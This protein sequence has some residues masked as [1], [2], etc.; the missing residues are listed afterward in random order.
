MAYRIVND[1]PGPESPARAA[2]AVTPNDDTDLAGGCRGL[3][4][5]TGGDL[6]LILA[7]DSAAVTFKNAISGT[8]L[9]LCVKRVKATGTTA[10]DIVALY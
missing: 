6:A 3:Y 9:P 8:V 4:V 1:R 5:G 2:A 7:E 10:T